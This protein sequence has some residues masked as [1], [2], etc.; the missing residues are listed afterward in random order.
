MKIF[1]VLFF[2]MDSSHIIFLNYVEN[3]DIMLFTCAPQKKKKQIH[4]HDY[5]NMYNDLT[6]TKQLPFGNAVLS[7]VLVVVSNLANIIFCKK[8][9]HL[10]FRV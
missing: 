8:F 7:P 2:L 6:T 5:Y 4:V 9:K 10:K 3:K 1:V